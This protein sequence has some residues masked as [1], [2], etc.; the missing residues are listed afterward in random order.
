MINNQHQVDYESDQ[1]PEFLPSIN[2]ALKKL[3]SFAK[4]M[5]STQLIELDDALHR[6]LAVDIHA[7]I[8]VPS[9]D[10]SAMDGYAI[11]LKKIK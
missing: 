10:N 7:N 8:S 2:K 1:T 9:F 11:N 6:I 5:D 4:V 3:I